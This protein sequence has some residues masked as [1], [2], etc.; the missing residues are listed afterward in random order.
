MKRIEQAVIDLAAGT[1]ITTRDQVLG[2]LEAVQCG[3]IS[4]T[5]AEERLGQWVDACQQRT[6]LF[7]RQELQRRTGGI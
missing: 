3:K 2:L 6:A 5:S 4:V 7:V 1:P